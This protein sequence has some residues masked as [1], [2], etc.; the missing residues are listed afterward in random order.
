[1]NPS[2]MLFLG[3]V[4]IFGAILLVLGTVGGITSERGQVSRSL[5]AIQGSGRGT[6]IEHVQVPFVDRVLAPGFGRLTGIARRLSPSG[7]SGQ[8]QR[9]LDVAGNPARWTVERILGY[10]GL[11]LLAGGAF[12]FLIGTHFGFVGLIMTVSAF[13]AFC[14]FLPDILVYN[15]GVKRQEK[16]RKT[17]AD[18]MDLLTISVEAGLGFDSALS[19]VAK[20]TDGPLA[21]EFFRVLQEMQIGKSRSESLRALGDRTTVPELRSFAGAVV[22]ADSLGIPIAH[23]LRAQAKEMR[24]KRYQRAE[25]AAQ[26]V[27]VKILFPL[28]LFIL[29][30]LF[31]VV[32]GPGIVGIVDAFSR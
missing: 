23:V 15:T 2:L 27:P 20:N 13:G 9:R 14:F 11:G 25:E 1:M 17:L 16:I 32:I 3:L 8:I 18:A 21:G 29:P 6:V 10:K 5:A 4:G 28:V 30:A 24:I 26:K 22:Q 12:G 7:I 19:Q 31:V